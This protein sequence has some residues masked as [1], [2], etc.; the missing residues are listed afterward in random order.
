MP[1][2]TITLMYLVVRRYTIICLFGIKFTQLRYFGTITMM[3]V[4][5]Y[6]LVRL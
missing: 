5:R 1:M 3:Y 4:L 6:V 2:T